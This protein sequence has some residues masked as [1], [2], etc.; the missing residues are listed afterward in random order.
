VKED[1]LGNVDAMQCEEFVKTNLE[2]DLP[3]IFINVDIKQI[4]RKLPL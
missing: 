1:N 3:P 4:S 2:E